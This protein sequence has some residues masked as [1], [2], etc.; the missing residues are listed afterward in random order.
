MQDVIHACVVNRLQRGM[1]ASAA[2][3]ERELVEKS[4]FSV[5][6]SNTIDFCI[7][8]LL[9]D[10]KGTLSQA[11]QVVGLF[12]DMEETI[13]NYPFF[14]VLVLTVDF[15]LVCESQCE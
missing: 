1:L 10:L 9:H 13:S 8:S 3:W 5:Y 11:K 7:L 2:R 6:S 4:Q 12:E 14:K 15:L